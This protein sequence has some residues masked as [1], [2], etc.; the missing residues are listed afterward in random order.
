MQVSMARTGS[1]KGVRNQEEGMK[2][3]RQDIQDIQDIQDEQD[4]R[5]DNRQL[6]TEN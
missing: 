1:D 5:T 3:I 6:A 2:G 4:D